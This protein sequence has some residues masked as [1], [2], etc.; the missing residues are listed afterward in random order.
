M[1]SD[2]EPH[3]EYDK[4]YL[5]E[6]NKEGIQKI[7]DK[8]L[9]TSTDKAIIIGT[10]GN[11]YFR[12]LY[13]TIESGI[14]IPFVVTPVIWETIP[15][16]GKTTWAMNMALSSM[17]KIPDL[18]ITKQRKLGKSITNK[19]TYKPKYDKPKSKFHK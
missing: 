13:E 1:S 11:D 12:A 7:L 9:K 14:K 18:T 15:K 5:S 6:H 8:N 10:A 17:I 2:K 3:I 16:Y 4:D 19:S